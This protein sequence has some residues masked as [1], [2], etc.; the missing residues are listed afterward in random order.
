MKKFFSKKG[1]L[2][3]GFFLT[4]IVILVSSIFIFTNMI[5]RLEQESNKQLKFQVEVFEALLT[6]QN[7]EDVTFLFQSLIKNTSYPA[8]Y[9]DTSF[10]AIYWVNLDIDSNSIISENEQIKSYINNFKEYAEPIPIQYETFLLGY[11]CYGKPPYLL[12][13][14]WLPIIFIAVIAVLLIV[15]YSGIMQIKRNEEQFIWVGLA[16]ETAHQ[17]GTPISSISG[18][19]EILKENPEKTKQY[20]EE[21]YKDLDRL[22]T[23]SKR[24]SQIGSKEELELSSL[25]N[26][27]Q[28]IVSYFQKRLP[29]YS[30]EIKLNL[31]IKED[32]QVKINKELFSWV[33]ENLIRNSI[34]SFAGKKGT[35]D[36]SV[37]IDKSIVEIF[38]SDDGKGIP[39]SLKR[40]IFEPGFTTKRRGWGLGLSLAKRIVERYHKGKLYLQNTEENNGTTFCIKIK[41]YENKKI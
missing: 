39:S 13:L 15:G 28:D 12:E 5:N 9:T 2:K 7:T 41:K 30:N 37:N 14:K 24:F 40:K 18:W 36:I 3:Q 21:F 16:K 20:L 33:M 38:V 4:L 8:V 17:L 10:N 26:I 1:I 27:L 34:D 6:S 23:V 29:R 22:K 32:V 35:I 31:E 25:N 19:L 11:Y